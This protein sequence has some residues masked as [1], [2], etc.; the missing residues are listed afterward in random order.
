MRYPNHLALNEVTVS[1][2]PGITGL[3]GHNGAGKSTLMK[4]LL[5]LQRPTAGE[6]F[7]AGSGSGADRLELRRQFGYAPEGDCLPPGESAYEFVAHLAQLSGLP[8]GAARERTGDVLRHVG[9]G[10]AGHRQMGTYS[11]GM[12]QRT[13]MAQALVHD[14]AI[15]LLDEPTNGLDP[16]GRD[17]MLS[18][19]R[20]MGADFGTS[21]LVSSHLLG[22]LER[23]CDHIIVLNHGELEHAGPLG[24]MTGRSGF[25]RIQAMDSSG[26]DAND[27]LAQVL[28]R[29][30]V[31]ARL[32]GRDLLVAAEAEV[33]QRVV[34]A[35]AAA[36]LGLTRMEP[37]RLGLVDLIMS[38]GPG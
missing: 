12:K 8:A 29:A 5:G 7:F 27:Q 6:V 24:A 32:N 28:A 14:P 15:V 30:G 25:L 38:R 4:I 18:L 33:A 13:K 19:I 36:G 20:R 31:A 34:A 11:T 2:P 22:E 26:Q 3:V 1:A 37:A 23:A 9:L 16:A 17:E 10:E 35:C 21:V